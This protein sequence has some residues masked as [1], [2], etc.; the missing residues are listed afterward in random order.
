M[1]LISI[2]IKKV[3]IDFINNHILKKEYLEMIALLQTNIKKLD[4]EIYTRRLAR[5]EFSFNLN[6]NILKTISNLSM[7]VVSLNQ[8][9]IKG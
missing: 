7:D 2:F 5:K 6:R 3:R 8:S 4:E 1:R 9:S